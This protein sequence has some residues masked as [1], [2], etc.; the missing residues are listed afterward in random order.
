MCRRVDLV[1]PFVRHVHSTHGREGGDFVSDYPEDS[2]IRSRL[3]C[4]NVEPRAQPTQQGSRRQ[5]GRRGGQCPTKYR[6]GLAKTWSRI[7]GLF[8]SAIFLHTVARQGDDIQTPM[9][10][11][12]V[13]ETVHTS[14]QLLF[15][16]LRLIG[17]YGVVP[18]AVVAEGFGF[19]SWHACIV[20]PSCTTGLRP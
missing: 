4:C 9:I 10:P 14:P 7:D 6:T 13:V 3:T 16:C 5:R 1:I 11:N 12:R 18:R 20:R 17:E 19:L 15:L 2:N 8:S